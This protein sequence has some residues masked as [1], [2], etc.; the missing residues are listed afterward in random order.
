[1]SE[2]LE[3]EENFEAEEAEEWADPEPIGVR[4]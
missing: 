2:V 1:M 3:H 4:L